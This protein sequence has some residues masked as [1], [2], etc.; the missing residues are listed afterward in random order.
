MT[1]SDKQRFPGRIRRAVKAIWPGFD[2]N[3]ND[4]LKPY[5]MFRNYLWIWG[6]AILFLL[7]TALLPFVLITFIHY[8]LIDTSVDTESFLRT[9]QVA[10]AAQSAVGYFFEE[11]LAALRFTAGTIGYDELILPRHLT[12]VLRNLKL[13]FG[14]LTDLSVIDDT[15]RQVAYAGPFNLTGKDYS[16]Q[17]W[18]IKC[19]EDNACVSD[20]FSGYRKMPH[21]VVAVKFPRQG[22]HLFI[23]RATLETERLRHILSSFAT[24]DKTDI[25]LVNREGLIQSPSR[26]YK[27]KSSYIT[28]P[29]PACSRE[30]KVMTAH[31]PD[32]PSAVVGHACIDTEIV[33]TPFVLLV[34][35]QKTGRMKAWSDLR[36][37]IN[38]ILFASIGVIVFAVVLV[39][40]FL[41]KKIFQADDQK[42]RTMAAAEQSC[43]LAAIG[44]L[45]AGVAHEINNPLALINETAGYLKD[46]LEIK[47]SHPAAGQGD[48]QA[49]EWAD[50]MDTIIDAVNRCSAIT[51]QLLG[52]TRRADVRMASVDL[53]Q[54]VDDIL[55]FHR[56]AAETR[57]ITI[58]VDIP[59]NLPSIQTDR[60]KLQQILLNLTTN[61]IQALGDGGRLDIRARMNGA[62]HVDIDVRDNGCGISEEN[63]KHIFEPFFTTKKEGQGTG[64][65]LSITQGLVKKIQGDIAVTSQPG[66]GTI[67]V[68]TLP[69]TPGKACDADTAD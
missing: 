10:S 52:L 53:K 61:A 49:G 68:V 4:H 20:V 63:R 2:L 40:T 50:H 1:S 13:G 30:A 31:P 15:G 45:A 18:F 48:G 25:F 9:E 36:T 66:Q 14:G 23:L 41:V 29:V 16:R 22:R 33:S 57:H 6:G 12:E 21:M 65:G 54:T 56:K 69:V 34:V 17:P 35:K 3:I 43:Q 44:Q 39:S 60:G 47:Q 55:R 64:L 5:Y 62:G 42:A 58:R 38:R 28:F 51:R 67:F 11:R 32:G 26:L 8:R 24:D 46:L 59:D 27:E 7:I 37:R 19:R